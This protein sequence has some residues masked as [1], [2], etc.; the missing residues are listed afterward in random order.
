MGLFRRLQNKPTLFPR[1]R[2]SK[3]TA[4]RALCLPSR[5]YLELEAQRKSH[6]VKTGLVR[7]R[8]GGSGAHFK[9][10]L[11]EGLLMLFVGFVVRKQHRHGAALSHVGGDWAYDNWTSFE[12][13]EAIGASLWFPCRRMPGSNGTATAKALRCREMKPSATSVGRSKEMKTYMATSI[14]IP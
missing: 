10:E 14:R 12:A 1:L 7:L 8:Q 13:I 9:T 6:V 4:S 3:Q 11:T 5:G 2:T